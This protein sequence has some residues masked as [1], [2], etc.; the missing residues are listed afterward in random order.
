MISTGLYSQSLNQMIDFHN[1]RIHAMNNH[2]PEVITLFLYLIAIIPYG[3]AGIWSRDQR[4]SKFHIQLV[5]V[6]FHRF[7]YSAGCR[8]RPTSNIQ[9]L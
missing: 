2:M 4:T 9:F 7:D 5:G 3:F 6:H 1:K 8:Y